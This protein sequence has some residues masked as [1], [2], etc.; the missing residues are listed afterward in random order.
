MQLTAQQAYELL[1]MPIG[2][3]IDIKPRLIT[4]S[5]YRLSKDVWE[6]SQTADGWQTANV[7]KSDIL[8]LNTG[9]KTFANLGWN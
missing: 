9:S 3:Q 4:Y 8:E 2:K 1:N 7:S 5:F 6:I